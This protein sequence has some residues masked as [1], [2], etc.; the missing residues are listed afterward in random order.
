MLA[1]WSSTVARL[2]ARLDALVVVVDGHGEDLLGP[3]LPDHVLVEHGLDLRGLGEAADLLTL[4]LLP[5]LRDDV[6]AELDALVADVHGG[7]GDE[8]ADIVL[9]LAAERALQRPSALARPGRHL[10]Y[11]TARP[12]PRLG[13]PS[14][15]AWWAWRR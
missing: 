2:A 10:V 9:A 12:P 14:L 11:P 5:L 8:L 6:V 15:T 7:A 4:L 13:L 1:F 3:V